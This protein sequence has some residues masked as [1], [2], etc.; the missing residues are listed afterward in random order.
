M[1]G[2]HSVRGQEDVMP[3]FAQAATNEFGGIAV[4]FGY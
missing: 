1:K 3:E 4:V 2:F